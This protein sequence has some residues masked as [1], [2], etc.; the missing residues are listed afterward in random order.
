MKI[1]TEDVKF[2]FPGQRNNFTIS[3]IRVIDQLPKS[4]AFA[5]IYA[6]GINYNHTLIHLKSE[7]GKSFN[8]VLEIY[9]RR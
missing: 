3:A 9:G 5:Q 2:P 1:V 6:G 7:R 8:F 4:N